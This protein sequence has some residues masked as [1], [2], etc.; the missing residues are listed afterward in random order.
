M[1]RLALL[2][3]SLTM[4]LGL[5]AQADLVYSGGNCVSSMVCDN[6]NV[7][8]WGR[9]KSGSNVGLLGT[10]KTAEKLTTMTMVP[11]FFQNNITVRQVNSGSGSHFIALDCEGNVYC[12]GNNS[13]GQ[14]GTLESGDAEKVENRIQDTPAR[15]KIGSNG[16]NSAVK[17]LAGTE[18]D[19]N[20]YLC[21]VAVVYAG[22]NSSFA[23]LGGTQYK[24]CLVSWGGNAQ[25]FDSQGYDN[26]YGQLGCGNTNNQKYPVFVLDANKNPLKNVVQVFAG[27]NSAYALVDDGTPNDGIGT[28]YSWGYQKGNGSL[29]RSAT[30]GV[31]NE[32]WDGNDP[33]ARPVKMED[34]S[35]LSNIKML[36]CGDGIG[37]GLD[38]DGYI[39]S[40]GNG[41]WNN[42]GGY[43]PLQQNGTQYQLQWLGSSATPKRV[44]AGFT[45]GASND[46]TY[47]LAKYV[48]G[49]QGFGMAITVDN[50]PVAWG[51][52]SQ[53]NGGL[54]GNGSDTPADP[55]YNTATHYIQ[56]GNN[57]VHDDVVLIN[58]GDTW[59]FYGRGDGSVWAWGNNA[60]G[61]AGLGSNKTVALYAE[62]VNLDPD[63]KPHAQDPTVQM[64]DDLT[65]C[66]S[67]FNGTLI[68]SGFLL[69]DMDAMENYKMTW[70]KDGT[71]VSTGS[72][73]QLGGTDY[74][75]TEVGT[76]DVLIEYTGPQRGCYIYEPAEGS[77]KISAYE[78]KFTI[79][80][81][82]FCGDADYI[83]VNVNA[84]SGSKAVYSWY[85]K[86]TAN[87]TPIGT[88][89]GSASTSIYIGDIVPNADGSKTIYVEE[90]SDGL[91]SFI[92]SSFANT[93]GSQNI[94]SLHNV[95]Y[96]A[97]TIKKSAV[98]TDFSMKVKAAIKYTQNVS[99]SSP[100]D[101][102]GTITVKVGL[103]PAKYDQNNHP[104]P[105]TDASPVK[106][107]QG[108]ATVTQQ[109]TSQNTYNLTGTVSFDAGNYDL[110]VGTYF[111]VIS[112]V[113]TSA[114]SGA[115]ID[116][117]N[118]FVLYTSN[119]SIENKADSE[120]G[121]FIVGAGAADK[122]NNY[123]SNDAGPFYDI[124][125]ATPQKFC[126][127][128][129]I[130]VPEDCPCDAPANF[131]IGLVD[132]D[133]H[134]ISQTKDTVIVCAND[135]HCT[136]TTTQW[137]A[138]ATAPFSYIWYKDGVVQGQASGTPGIQSAPFAVSEGGTY[139]ILV[140][141]NTAP[142]VEKC[143]RSAEVLV[144]E[145]PVPTVKVSGGGE[146]CE[147]DQANFTSPVTFTMT[148]EPKFRVYWD[149][150]DNTGTT[151]SKNKR[152]TAYTV[153]A[154]VPTAVGEHTY[155]VTSVNDDGNCKN[156]AVSGTAKIV[157][158]PRPTATLTPDPASATICE[159]TGS[160]KLT[161]ASDPTGA[162]FAWTKDGAN[163][164]SGSEKT[165]T[166]PN[167]SGVYSIV[168]T[169]NSCPGDAVSQEV[170]INP[171]PEIKTLTSDKNAVC[172]GGTITLTATVS[173]AGDGTFTWS[174]DGVTGNGATATVSNDVTTDTEVTITLNYTSAT[175][176][177][178]EAKTIKVTF[179]AYPD[180][181]TVK[182]QAYC[183]DDTPKQLEATPMSGA[184]LNWYGNNETGGTAS[185]VAPTPS[186]AVATNPA[187]YYYVSQTIN[188]C[189]SKTR[190]KATVIV[191]DTLSPVITADPGFEVCE[192]TPIN[193]NVD[194][195][196]QTTTWSGSGAAK[197]DAT[198]IQTPTFNATE[199]TYSVRVQVED[200]KGCKGSAEKTITVNPTPVVELS[201]LTNECLSNETAQTL[202]A[203]V[204]PSGT[205]GTGTW[206]GDVTKVDE[207]KAS[208]TP[209]IAGVGTHEIT[210]DFESDKH[211]VAKQVKTSVEVFKMPTPTISVSNNS[212]CVSGNNSDVVTVTTQGTEAN[213]TF[214]YSINNGGTVNASD[215]S[216]DPTANAAKNDPYT[217]TLDYKDANGCPGTAS[218]EVTV[219]ALPTVE[220]TS[221]NP[222]ELCYNGGAIDVATNVSP[223]GGTGVWTGTESS[224]SNVFDPKVKTVGANAI[225]Y[226]YT[227]IYKCQNSDDFSIEVKKPAVPTPGDDVN[228]MINNGNLAGIVPMTAT[229][230]TPAD[231]L[232]WW[233]PEAGNTII[234][235][236]T[237]YE[238]PETTVGSYHYLVR[239]MLTVNGG[240]CYSDS[241]MVTTNISA[242]NAMAPRASDIYVCVGTQLKEFSATQTSTLTN[243]KISWLTDNPVGKNGTEADSWILQDASTT[244]TPAASSVNL[245]TAGE[246]VYYAAE[247]D[248]Q[249]NCWSAGTKVTLHVVANPVVTISSPEHYCAKGTDRVPVTVTPQNGVI[250]ADAGSMDGFNWMPGD[251]SGD[252]L[253]VE[254]TY[255]VTSDAYADGT[256]CNTTKTSQT[257]AHFMEA[258]T[259]TP[260]NWLIGNIDGMTSGLLKGVRL[261]NV[262][263]YITWYDTQTKTNKLLDQ[264][265]S[266]TPDKTALKA[267]VGSADTYVKSY[268]I[269]QTDAHNCESVPAEVIL[270][271]IDCPWE[272]PT[273]TGDKKCHGFDLDPLKG[274]QGASVESQSS[275]T[276]LKWNWYNEQKSLITTTTAPA[277]SEASYPHGLS[278]EADGT[279]TFYVS[280]SAN[281]KNSGNE[282]E[283]PM[284]KVTVTVLPLPT[285]TF[286]K[287]SEIVCYTTEETKINVNAASANGTG[288]G[289]WSITG[290]PSAISSNGI[291]YAKANGDNAG[292]KQYTITYTYT[293]AEECEFSN[294][295]TIDVIYLPA[296]E[297]K[298]FY[299]MTSQSNPVEVKV[300]SSMTE[301]AT[302]KW[303]ESATLVN[304]EK[305]SGTS[306][307]T[308]DA[309][310]L[311]VDKNYY[312]R[313]FKEGCY[314][315]STVANV[316]IVPCPIPSVEISDE[317]ACNYAEIPTMVASTGDWTERDASQSAFKFYTSETAT[318]QE[319]ISPDGTY[320]PSLP[321][322]NNGLT[323]DGDYTYYVSEYN[324]EPLQ[325][326]TTNEGC[327]GPRKA[328]K[329]TI[330]GTLAPI[331]AA[332]GE[333]AVCEGTDNPTF[334]ATNYIGT[335]SWFEEDPGE[336]GE[337]QA[338]VVG[339]DKTFTPNGSDAGEYTIWAVQKVN[340]CYGP[341]ASAPYT[342]KS[343]P[344]A[345][346]TEGA[347]LCFE[348]AALPVKATPATDGK[349]NWYADALKVTS[350]S[351]GQSTYQSKETL[352]GE[353][354]YYASQVVK[355]CESKTNPV[356]YHIK[357]RPGVPVITPQKNLCEYEEAPLLEAN[358]EN[359][360][361]YSSP[362]DKTTL[363]IEDE[364]FQ[365][366]D[367]TPGTK[368]YYASQ[369]VEG[370][371]GDAVMLSFVV[372]S[373]PAEPMVQGANVC[374]GAE[375]IPSL[376]TNMPTDKWYAEEAGVTVVA[377]GY[378]Y[379][380]EAAE[381][382]NLDKT[383]Y[384]Q[385]EI[386]GC[387]SDMVPVVLHVVQ[388]PEIEISNDMAICVYEDLLP[389]EAT[390]LKPNANDASSIEWQVKY[391]KVTKYFEDDEGE[392]HQV[393][394][395]SFINTEGDYTVSAVYKYVFENI[396]CLSDTVSMNYSIK[397]QPRKPIV[398][399][400]VI[401]QGE[402]IKDLQALGSPNM[403]WGS[404][405]GAKP[406]AATGT[407][408]HFDPGQVLDTGTYS[409]MVYD[410]SIY[411]K[412]NNLG[413][414]SEVDTVY[415]T[416]APAAKTKLFGRDS[417][418]V[419]AT[420]QYY[421]QFTKE[422]SYFWNVTG[423]HLN[424][425]KDAMSS[426]VRYVDWMKSGIDTLTVY[427]QTWAGCEGWDTLVV[428]I[429]A[430]PKALYKWE[431]PGASN[432][433][434]LIDSTVQDTLWYTN[435][436]G[437]LQA[438]PV[439]YTL[440]WNYGHIGE[441]ENAIDTVIAYDQRKFPLLEGN[442]IYGYN[443]PILTVENSFGCKDV[444][445]E[446]I[447]VNVTSSIYVPTAFAPM[448]PAHSVRTFQP[449]G[450]NLKTC[451][452]SVFDKWGNLL[453]HSDAVEDGKFVGSWDGR[454]EGKMLKSDV[455][456]WKME[457][458][459]LD[460]QEWQ[461]FDV[462][463]GKKAKFGSVTLV[464]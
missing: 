160:V 348:E 332:T 194:G 353:Y 76:Y 90:T 264:G 228:A 307:A 27:D 147:G 164:G 132:G 419:G 216:F 331:I 122:S 376:S 162:T 309:T 229:M 1:K 403:M 75:A 178:A 236:T 375:Q 165:L 414:K 446:C 48:S 429:A 443:C 282:C 116:G 130:D 349:I 221:A 343:I 317:I 49:G 313:Q 190:A 146:Y 261:A 413:C 425:S 138:S 243:Q 336:V 333:A 445:K 196:F 193:L 381:I 272:A 329:I 188:G 110:P 450:Y 156:E 392:G 187:I 430:M 183:V 205:N 29:G 437:E 319:K 417:V 421:T 255:T 30:G 78:Q 79:P 192:N 358:G 224:S 362:S 46:G 245:T 386:N 410:V 213:G 117:N 98:L 420:E 303:F 109:A 305:G 230:N 60:D 125:F 225:S 149:Y 342:I 5:F 70:K 448:N 41:A 321:L 177:E 37:Y 33:Y 108:T 327:E 222:T 195:T 201:T 270:N 322:D 251:Y 158:K 344:D 428:K 2:V 168:P 401:C 200:M 233:Y 456:I 427:E 111:L 151:K 106:T 18:Y 263:E 359:V 74:F 267:E 371:E 426:S 415:M 148:G 394:P 447:F 95:P 72:I 58:R 372:N 345:P 389:I 170:T 17:G 404:L 334:V 440:F 405:D 22:N 42:S 197:L 325:N 89:I 208:Y 87:A 391:G 81:F 4:A 35:N 439:S 288:S 418:C 80:D 350:L 184:T 299:A 152:S 354:T 449:K 268:W 452:I 19:C 207:F 435:K 84:A 9:N 340:D 351:S 464:R 32:S 67:A 99:S 357:A 157:V 402:D 258:P 34:G 121:T 166:D 436:E 356:V 155:T 101:M 399:S 97:L 7:F 186:T 274:T 232:Q 220:I 218:A 15:V 217:I 330:S 408:Y 400:S 383:Y 94:Y 284:T 438:D 119:K 304:E 141:D 139:K 105:K 8:V 374:E 280:Y 62:R 175:T 301:N 297:T 55:Q 112:D 12:W 390:K 380:P 457:A 163:N 120:G 271:L 302:A 285:V 385:R 93:N 14:C 298:G 252:N 242:C 52:A 444:Y 238:S 104:Q 144:Q 370:C 179:Y 102:T 315:E 382:G 461:G 92:P 71:V 276:S 23:I 323:K 451:E 295:R 77:V 219:H 24:G 198:T 64:S 113:Q 68:E 355:D 432:L 210:Y 128:I 462:G 279:T 103:Y 118:T 54:T 346:V 3:G 66:A 320:K 21:H 142:T 28:V 369:T 423:D 153:E 212:V 214:T 384:V 278:K 455:Y 286:D 294:S 140:Y 59:G 248:G 63:C 460:G 167:Q 26:C 43:M 314:S 262:G 211:C 257:T 203:I 296:P 191:D 318:T 292:Q 226:T 13:L 338:P 265:D 289:V 463:H 442:Y 367:M 159:G 227:D 459:F 47:L 40:W 434:E 339:T 135:P 431:M 433:I 337:P 114:S 269:T 204:T 25:G 326:L 50:K 300:T 137:A 234:S 256:T 275:S 154:D 82:H 215:G 131:T 171:K 185:S 244:F 57:K 174:G 240:G 134:Y 393:T 441:D 6:G 223:A 250:S 133:N 395:S 172:S 411:D 86:K 281:E 398:F 246:Y 44:A 96:P 328:V 85:N 91:G 277:G 16:P 206:T 388:K 360:K 412:E 363:L 293:D 51:G 88:T 126:T 73:K 107:F 69:T 416:V 83:D 290:D 378:N 366:T 143:Q 310:N 259:S 39:W 387:V 45:T 365:T 100:V 283:S 11:Y 361:W 260:V 407:K 368:R 458:T 38:T 253:P 347:V 115:Q 316:K 254:F 145:N 397:G 324:S 377:V 409:F 379:T 56:Y 169:L 396:Y 373:Q 249:E 127:R 182:D 31:G 129:A 65:V 235:E 136:L 173:D 308:G 123:K 36:G 20:G 454:Y 453:W 341:K 180:A 181:P 311:T 406:Y 209:S 53:T 239:S 161:A 199:G 124:N 273:V 422:S 237:S 312:A 202:K 335:I 176:C 287:Q 306:W 291:F 61:Q 150:T 364:S 352:P 424:Y 247:Y 266:Y 231:K 189:E 10:G 241:V